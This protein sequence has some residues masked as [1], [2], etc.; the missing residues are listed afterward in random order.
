M[1]ANA[2]K[3]CMST[4]KRQPQ[5]GVSVLTVA[6]VSA[7]VHGVLGMLIEPLF[8][9]AFLSLNHLKHE[10]IWNEK[11]FMIAFPFAYG[12]IGFLIGGV[13]TL[14]YNHLVVNFLPKETPEE[15]KTEGP[16]ELLE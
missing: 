14:L 1:P 8:A 6:L 7:G 2:G 5:K 9:S 16:L 10:S 3:V 13:A 15:P 11:F 12:L 4:P